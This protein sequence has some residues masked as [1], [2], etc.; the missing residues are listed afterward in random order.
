MIRM[1][2]R[3]HD[4]TIDAVSPNLVKHLVNIGLCGEQE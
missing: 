1:E 4:R 3:R 2:P